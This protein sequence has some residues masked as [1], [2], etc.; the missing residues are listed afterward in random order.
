[1]FFAAKFSFCFVYNF[2]VFLS[3]HCNT[4]NITLRSLSRWYFHIFISFYFSV[5]AIFSFLACIQSYNSAV[6]TRNET[7]GKN[8]F[9]RKIFFSN[10]IKKTRMLFKD[11]FKITWNR[12]SNEISV[13]HLST[14]LSISSSILSCGW[15]VNF[16][17]QYFDWFLWL[18]N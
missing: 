18:K 11:F 5:D 8:C 1:M 10:T 15:K 2:H 6:H 3:F 17:F 7:G 13:T 9:S 16:S 14:C 4:T 12:R